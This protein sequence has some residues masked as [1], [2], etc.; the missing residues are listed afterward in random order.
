MLRK[1]MPRKDI[2]F[3]FMEQQA[4]KAVEAIQALRV[5]VGDLENCGAHRDRVKVIEHEADEIAHRAIAEL[6]RSFITPMDRNDI[7]RM[8]KRLDDVVDLVESVAQRMYYYDLR[9]APP[10]LTLLVEV[11]E[12]QIRAVHGVIGRLPDMTDT[13]P[14]K[15]ALVQIHTYEN[16]A[17]DILRP[18]IA[19][20][21][22][23]E[24]DTKMLIK[25]KEVYEHLERATDRCE[26]IA[27]LVE[28]I[29]LEYA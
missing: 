3:K 18:A 22:R 5:L 13:D 11:L 29:L 14:I 15:Q 7:N 19:E 21:F 8:N 16:E 9:V 1:L 24:S 2:F 27:D 20:L 6:H 12:K 26:D 17:D 25:W 28:N 10:S 4:A 23:K